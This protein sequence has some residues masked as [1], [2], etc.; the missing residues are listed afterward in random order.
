AVVGSGPAGLA[1]AQQLT[2]AGHTVVVYERDDAIGGLLRYG[3]PD[4]KMEKSVLDR[5]IKQMVLEGTVFKTNTE[6][7]VDIT[8]EQLRERFD[9]VV[10]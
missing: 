5:R 8:G 1:T 9:A 7:G 10:L 6:I 4:F 3:I 2:R